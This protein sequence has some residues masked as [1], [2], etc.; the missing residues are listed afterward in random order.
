[1]I[2]LE[3]FLPDDRYIWNDKMK[4]IINDVTNKITF[5]CSIRQ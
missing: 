5:R 4:G 3:M 2:N 1:M